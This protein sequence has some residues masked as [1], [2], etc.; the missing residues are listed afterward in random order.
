MHLG[1]LGSSPAVLDSH[2]PLSSDE[3]FICCTLNTPAHLDV[4]KLHNLKGRRLTR[5][6]AD[7]FHNQNI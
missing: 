7:R 1:G 6:E 5:H 2:F 3:S 4:E